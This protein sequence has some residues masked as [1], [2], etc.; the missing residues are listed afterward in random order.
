[1]QKNPVSG[2]IPLKFDQLWCGSLK[3]IVTTS[4][5]W[6]HLQT[7]L[8]SRI[9]PTSTDLGIALTE[10]NTMKKILISAVIGIGAGL[11]GTAS[12]DV[13]IGISIGIPGVVV[14]PAPVYVAPPPPVYYA[15]APVV[16][17]PPAYGY[18]AAP[19]FRPPIVVSGAWIAG[20]PR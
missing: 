4:S 18:Y 2:L 9:S 3:R 7:W 15:P 10:R 13:G 6:F 19:A 14:A 5:H 1:M 17:A 11:S 8:V 16:V 12:A 20:G